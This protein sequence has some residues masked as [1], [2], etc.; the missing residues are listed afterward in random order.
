MLE[1]YREFRLEADRE[2]FRHFLEAFVPNVPGHGPADVGRFLADFVVRT[3]A[4]IPRESRPVFLKMPYLGPTAME[5][6]A[7]YDPHLVPGILGGSSGR[8]MTPRCSAGRRH[9]ARA[10][11]FGRKIRTAASADLRA[12]PAAAQRRASRRRGG[13]SRLPR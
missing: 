11:L 5:A 10:A 2:N 12:L 9:G 6:L 1:R 7:S 13:V 8:R 3:L 4:A